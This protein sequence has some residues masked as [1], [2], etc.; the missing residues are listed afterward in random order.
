MLSWL[1]AQEQHLP[2]PPPS[3]SCSARQQL[4]LWARSA[5]AIR[6]GGLRQLRELGDLGMFLLDDL[7]PQADRFAVVS[8]GGCTVAMVPASCACG[9]SLLEP[10][11]QPWLPYGESTHVAWCPDGQHLAVS[12]QQGRC[13]RVSIFSRANPVRSFVEPLAEQE[14]CTALHGSAGAAAVLLTIGSPA[15]QQTS[16]QQRVVAASA[17]GSITRHPPVDCLC[18]TLAHNATCLVGVASAADRLYV[19]STSSM[20]TVSLRQS[21]PGA[22]CALASSWGRSV[23]V[24]RQGGSGSTARHALLLVDLA[25]Q[26]LERG[27]DLEQLCTASHGL[28]K[29][30]QGAYS[31]AVLPEGS[32]QVHVLATSGPVDFGRHRFTVYGNLFEWDPTG[33]FLAVGSSVSGRLSVMDGVSGSFLASWLGLAADTTGRVWVTQLRW[34]P[35]SAGLLCGQ[36]VRMGPGASESDSNMAEDDDD[37]V[38]TLS[39]LVF[40]GA[41]CPFLMRRC[42]H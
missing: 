11:Q 21:L 10:E 33:R 40:A 12:T 25:G 42:Q 13:L 18:W 24:W 19:C 5:A 30:R 35:G 38:H 41:A 8:R 2:L 31:A 23:S 1:W 15:S 27:C 34:L 20:V 22:T 28:D 4:D 6:A 26:C 7:S 37:D 3:S 36:V 16:R 9:R 32:G 17:Q 14:T 29:L 39:V